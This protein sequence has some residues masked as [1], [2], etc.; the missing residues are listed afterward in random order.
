MNNNQNNIPEVNITKRYSFIA[1]AKE[2]GKPELFDDMINKETGEQFSIIK[3]HKD[4]ESTDVFFGKSVRDY[5]YDDIVENMKD[6]E[7]G[8]ADNGKNYLY[9]PKKGKLIA[10]DIELTIE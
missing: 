4:D 6:L 3:F 5:T 7:V 10:M 8:I 9:K 1:F 2:F